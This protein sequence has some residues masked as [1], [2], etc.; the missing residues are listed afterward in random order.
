MNEEKCVV[1][2]LLR[3]FNMEAT[4]TMEEIGPV[5]EMVLRPTKGIDIK[6]TRRV[7]VT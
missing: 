3:H 7:K 5:P 2:A 1:S 4:Q 6:F